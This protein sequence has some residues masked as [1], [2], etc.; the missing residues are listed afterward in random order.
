[1]PAPLCA[2][3]LVLVP[4]CACVPGA[5]AHGRLATPSPA[6]APTSAPPRAG[7]AACVEEGAARAPTPV[8]TPVVLLPPYRELPPVPGHRP[9][10]LVP[11]AVLAPHLGTHCTGKCFACV[12]CVS[13]VPF[14]CRVYAVCVPCVCRVLYLP[15]DRSDER[16]TC[17]PR[18]NPSHAL[19][20]AASLES[21]LDQHHSGS[22][23]LTTPS[24]LGNLIAPP[25][26]APTGKNGR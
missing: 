22:Q 1:M 10:L 23:T 4:L 19:C 13:C 24:A 17:T 12:P 6:L 7:T 11:P 5:C 14:V 26:P 16:I 21:A 9:V 8:A 3:V 2:Y 25:I 18:P 20:T 15:L